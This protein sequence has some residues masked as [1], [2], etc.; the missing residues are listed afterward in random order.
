MFVQSW[1]TGRTGS[2]SS[3]FS[4]QF[5]FGN[6]FH[7]LAFARFSSTWIFNLT[8][9]NPTS[10][11]FV[12]CFWM[13]VSSHS[14]SPQCSKGHWHGCSC[15]VVPTALSSDKF[16]SVRYKKHLQQRPTDQ[17]FV[18]REVAPISECSTWNAYLVS[19]LSELVETPSGKI[20]TYSWW[21]P[22][23]WH[24]C[25]WYSASFASLFDCFLPFETVT[26]CKS[27]WQDHASVS[28]GK[29]V[30][31]WLS[32][33]ICFLAEFLC[34]FRFALSL[35]SAAQ[36]TLKA[37]QNLSK[38]ERR[39]RFLREMDMGNASSFDIEETSSL[40]CN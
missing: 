33:L 19:G 12:P 14:P 22:E 6:G 18:P 32:V 5:W 40:H 11:L 25:Q 37:V 8:G 38:R 2:A 30:I 39:L 15:L 36:D 3:Q 34:T 21:C 31:A 17:Y 35:S 7:F 26:A 27:W 28:G 29:L 4:S 20:P 1:P 16:C 13:F 9:S 23:E 10:F 24:H